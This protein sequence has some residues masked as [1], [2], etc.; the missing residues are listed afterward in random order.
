MSSLK[1][2]I[3]AGIV[4]AASNLLTGCAPAEPSEVGIKRLEEAQEMKKTVQLSL[5]A[6]ET[7]PENIVVQVILDNPERKPLTSAQSWLAYNP[8]VL[9][10]IS[11]NTKNSAFEL[12]APYRNDF[13]HE[14]GLVMIGRSSAFPVTDERIIVAEILFER[15]SD[16][17]LMIEAYDYK[18]DLSGHT[19][20]NMMQ[21]GEPVNILLKPQSPLPITSQ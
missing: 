18:Q 20:A 7:D 8:R 4:L 9:Q 6:D 3:A 14:A 16:G 21:N 2:I 12:E 19:S 5:T 17:V 15:L 10:G 13:D 11:I 1:I